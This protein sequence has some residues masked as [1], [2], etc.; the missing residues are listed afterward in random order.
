MK[1]RNL[2]LQ[3]TILL[4]ITVLSAFSI[5]II[6]V[7]GYVQYGRGRKDYFVGGWENKVTLNILQVSVG[8]P[9]EG[10]SA[11][12]TKTILN[13]DKWLYKNAIAYTTYEEVSGG[14]EWVKT[15]GEAQYYQHDGRPDVVVTTYIYIDW[16]QY[17]YDGRNLEWIKGWGI[18]YYSSWSW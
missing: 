3:I 8:D 14:Y 6:P 13:P 18:I 2:D 4:F 10:Y 17:F 11:S 16:D 12:H 5:C 7:K 9:I 1:K 15:V